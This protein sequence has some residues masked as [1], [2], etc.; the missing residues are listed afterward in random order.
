MRLFLEAHALGQYVDQLI[1]HGFDTLDGLVDINLELLHEAAGEVRAG[2]RAR[3]LR[4]T[5]GLAQVLGKSSSSIKPDCIHFLCFELLLDV[6]PRF[7]TFV[8]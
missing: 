3:L 8:S 6:E 7:R 1:T 5:A 4:H 2:H